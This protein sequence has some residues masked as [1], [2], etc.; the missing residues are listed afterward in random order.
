[1]GKFAAVYDL[2]AG[3][4]LLVILVRDE[5]TGEPMVQYITQIG[6]EM[7]SAMV[8]V[9]DEVDKLDHLKQ[10]SAYEETRQAILNIPEDH[11]KIIRMKFV[12]DLK[13]LGN[14]PRPT[15]ED[16]TKCQPN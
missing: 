6:D 4:Q 11:V 5:Q 13:A 15:K 10:L 2:P 8:P 3:E 14:G 7:A 9:L 1:M 12:Q 16:N